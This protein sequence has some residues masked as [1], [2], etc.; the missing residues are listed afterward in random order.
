MAASHRNRRT[1]NLAITGWGPKR[2]D[3]PSLHKRAA[4]MRISPRVGGRSSQMQAVRAGYRLREGEACLGPAGSV[5]IPPPLFQRWLDRLFAAYAMPDS[6]SKGAALRY[7]DG[8]KKE[9]RA[10]GQWSVPHEPESRPKHPANGSGSNRT[11]RRLCGCFHH[12]Q[13]HLHAADFSKPI[14]IVSRYCRNGRGMK[15]LQATVNGGRHSLQ[16][17]SVRSNCCPPVRA[18]HAPTASS[19][20]FRFLMKS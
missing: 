20:R 15:S 17:V 14:Y 3:S 12:H 19:P 5:I 1:A 18:P 8:W 11:A 7:G 9:N 6:Q 16:P 10:N 4:T 2:R 13:D